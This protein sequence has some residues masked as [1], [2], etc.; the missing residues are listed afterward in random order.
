MDI[1]SLTGKNLPGKKWSSLTDLA[2]GVEDAAIN[3]HLALKSIAGSGNATHMGLQPDFKFDLLPLRLLDKVA[4]DEKLKLVYTDLRTS[5][6]PYFMSWLAKNRR[7]NEGIEVRICE[8]SHISRLREQGLSQ[9]TFT[10]EKNE[11]LVRNYALDLIVNASK[12]GASDIHIMMRGTHADVQFE[13]QSKLYHFVTLFHDEGGAIVRAIFQGIAQTKSAMFEEL[14][15]QNAQISGSEFAFECQLSS[16]RIFRGPAF[17]LGAEGG[18]FMTIR[19]QYLAGHQIEEGL[20]LLSYP[21]RPAGDFDLE[22]M[23]YTRA[24]I[25]KIERL[26]NTPAGVIFFTGPTGSGKTSTLFQILQELARIRPYSRQVTVEDPPENPMPWAVQMVITNAKNDEEVGIE[27][28]NL[29]RGALRMAPK[30]LFLGEIRGPAVG[31]SVIEAALTGHQAWTTI[32]TPDPFLAI[33][34]LELMDHIR[35][36]RKRF[37]DHTIIR[38]LVAQRLLPK[39]CQYCRLPLKGNESVLSARLVKTLKSYGNVEQVNLSKEGGC[40]HCNFTGSTKRFAIAEVVVCDENL[41]HDFI[42][43]GTAIARKNYRARPESDLPILNQALA[44]VFA[45][46]VDPRSIEEIVDSIPIQDIAVVEL[47]DSSQIEVSIA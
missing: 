6:H 13:I 43:H 14:A 19:L 20:P 45:G 37:C 35:L 38:G 36:N 33:D 17:S 41:M 5:G 12:Y 40:E 22:R 24:Q 34:R 44:Q 9:K 2:G 31:L 28:A 1:K 30:I 4:I 7:R 25:I 16:C 29:V 46:Q 27:Y 18:S 23:G 15:Y 32:H 3:K 26:I 10:S 42:A 11:L 39:L 47:L 21:Q 8:I